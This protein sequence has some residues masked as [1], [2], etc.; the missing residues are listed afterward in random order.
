M[1][2]TLA[3]ITQ[4]SPLV[5]LDSTADIFA[6]V[7]EGPI[8][9]VR[10]GVVVTVALTTP[11]AV[12][13]ADSVKLTVRGD[14]DAGTITT[15]TSQAV[16]TGVYTETSSPDVTAHPTQPFHLK[17]GEQL[18][19]QV[20]T[21]AGAGDGILWI[22]YRNLSFVDSPTVDDTAPLTELGNFVKVAA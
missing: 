15:A 13:A 12:V 3:L 2:S 20:T 11:A 7:A 22:Q 14:G 10:W 1:T 9:V 21:A 4:K 16:G 18:I 19:F 17:G 5:A 6:F 8:E